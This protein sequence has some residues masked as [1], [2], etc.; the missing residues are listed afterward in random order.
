MNPGT[1]ISTITSTNP[2]AI[3]AHQIVQIMSPDP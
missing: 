1:M 2:K 3:Q